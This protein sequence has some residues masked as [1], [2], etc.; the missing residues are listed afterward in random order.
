[1]NSTPHAV[2]GLEFGGTKLQL[3]IGNAQG[4]IHHRWRF[5][6]DPK[7][8]APGIRARVQEVLPPILQT[9]RPAAIGAGFGG[10]LDHRSGL[11]ARSH[12]IE[13]WA[14]FNLTGW[15]TQLSGLP[16]AADNDANLA[17]LGESV[18]GAGQGLNPV[19][20]VTLGSGVGGGLVHDGSI[21]HGSVPGESEIGHLRLDRQGGTLESRCSGWAVDQRIRQGAATHPESKLSRLVQTSPGHEARHLGP[22]LLEGDAWAQEVLREIAETLAF[23]LSH[24]MHLFHPQVILLG[25]GLSLI[26]EPWR[27]AVAQ[28][29]P[30][31]VM[32]T[33]QD[34]VNIA[35][36]ALGEDA[37]PT[38]ALLLAGR[39]VSDP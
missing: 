16:A 29:L 21:Y 19:F 26:G 37:V 39:L 36:A 18:R 11:I 35:L 32:H 6:V 38:G 3:A 20:Y 31:H 27:L 8:G 10:P 33:F 30:S 23:G 15:L 12:Q 28:A 1:M 25:G 14:G 9:H 24:V 4:E 34:Q 7:A 13:G 5:A 2:L 22:A 17:A